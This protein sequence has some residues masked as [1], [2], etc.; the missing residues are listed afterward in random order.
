[1][2]ENEELTSENTPDTPRVPGRSAV[3]TPVVPVGSIVRVILIAMVILAVAALVATTFYLL[4]FLLFIVVL[5]IFFAYLLEPLV[6]FIRRPFKR[7]NLDSLMPRSVAIVIS[8]LLVFSILG[9]AIAN[10]AP[11]IGTQIQQFADDLPSY[12]DVIEERFARLNQRY[13]QLQL[14][15]EMQKIINDRVNSSITLMSDQLTTFAGNLAFN[16]FA[17]LPWLLLVPILA[18]FFLKDAALYRS[19]FL[20]CFP[21]GKWR[22][23]AESLVN[24]M[25]NTLAG[26]THAQ[27]VSGL[28]IGSLC[29]LAFTLIGLDYALLLGIL[30]GVLEFI[31]LLGPLVIGIAA[32][33]IGTFSEHPWNGLYVAVF[34][35]ALRLVQSFVTYPRIV[36][37]GVQIHPM[38]V[39][40][41]VLAGEQLAGIAGVFL[42]IPVV[43][44]LTVFYK[45][46]LEHSGRTS[47]FAELF[48]KKEAEPAETEIEV[49]P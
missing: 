45:Q 12:R 22:A 40:L 15:P 5:S 38:A 23:R 6:R 49:S 25:N 1:M 2:V 3:Q 30:A 26:Y 16:F 29:T 24:D 36:R 28:L 43:A 8:Y 34:L 4:S 46:F 18:F 14:S 9:A 17:Y 32:T 7:R 13:E 19:M 33:G 21:P 39:I 47:L 20:G 42:S 10:L 35:I 11:L 44:I 37:D 31:P 41:S 48:V 27:L